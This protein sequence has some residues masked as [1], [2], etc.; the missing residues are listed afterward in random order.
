MSEIEKHILGSLSEIKDELSAVKTQ[1]EVSNILHQS[2]AETLEK[3][4]KDTKEKTDRIE[5]DVDELDAEVELLNKIQAWW[6]ITGKLL[7]LVIPTIAIIA[8]IIIGK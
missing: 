6:G 5:A 8:G 7:V 2:N 4:I 3:H 1:I